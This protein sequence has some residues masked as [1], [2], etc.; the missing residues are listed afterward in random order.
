M[1]QCDREVRAS[2]PEKERAGSVKDLDLDHLPIERTLGIQWNVDKDCF[3]FN[4]QLKQKEETRRDILSMMSSV[5]DPLGF[6]SPYILLAKLILQ[7]LCCG[8]IGWD[9]CVG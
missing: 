9:E 1:A 3:E 7:E 4:V 8:G 2:I 6:L 5:F